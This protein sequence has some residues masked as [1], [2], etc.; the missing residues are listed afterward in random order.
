[1]RCDERCD[2]IGCVSRDWCDWVAGAAITPSSLVVFGLR[3]DGDDDECL[4]VVVSIVLWIS[5]IVKLK[6]ERFLE[7]VKRLL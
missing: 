2:E 5:L 6:K 3:L 4:M 1:M 7:T